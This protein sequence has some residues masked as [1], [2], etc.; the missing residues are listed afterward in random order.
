MNYV[1]TRNSSDSFKFED[2]FIKGLADDGGL[3]IPKSLHKYSQKDLNSF[4]NLQYTDLAKKIIYPFIGDFVNENDLSNIIDKSYSVFRKKNVVELNKVGDRSVLELFHGPTLAFKDIAMQLLGN[5]Y[6]YYLKSTNEKINIVVATSGD[7]G[8]AAIDAIKGKKNVNIF[9]LHPHNRVS[10]VQRKLMTTGN[11]KNVFNVAIKGN[12]DDCQNLVKAMFADKIFST[13][14]NMS[15]V[16]SI[17]WAR[18][19]SQSVY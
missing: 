14:I 9:V 2:V 13:S 12:F 16:N 6:E 1:S 3:F 10:P 8:A 11:E 5:F 7:T 4:E 19:I 15:G 17:N 18:I